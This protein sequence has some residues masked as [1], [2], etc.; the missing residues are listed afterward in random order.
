MKR[1]ILAVLSALLLSLSMSATVY[2]HSGRTDSNGG[3]Y[4]SSTGRYHYHHGYPAHY[5]TNGR[6]PYTSDLGREDGLDDLI[7]KEEEKIKEEKEETKKENNTLLG[8]MICV[9][10]VGVI[11][12]KVGE[13]KNSKNEE[14]MIQT[15]GV[16]L[17][18]LAGIYLVGLLIA[19][20]LGGL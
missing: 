6:C 13:S 11:L 20:I 1:I 5:H 8:I 18:V 4:D 19:F 14:T 2:A 17:C 9:F 16:C 15:I 10:I 12:C 7:K 3:H